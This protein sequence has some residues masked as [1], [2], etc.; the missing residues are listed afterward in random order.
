VRRS[1]LIPQ[2]QEDQEAVL[3]RRL[4]AKPMRENNLQMLRRRLSTTAIA[5]SLSGDEKSE[6]KEAGDQI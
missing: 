5:A 3:V 4:Q 2:E 1:E 6:E